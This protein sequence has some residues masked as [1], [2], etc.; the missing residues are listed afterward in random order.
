MLRYKTETRPS[1]VALYDIRLGN[2]AGQ[3]LQSRSLQGASGRR[4]G[5]ANVFHTD[6]ITMFNENQ[7]MLK[8][9]GAMTMII[10]QLIVHL[11]IISA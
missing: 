7:Q 11:A 1:L 4:G 5:Q 3:F 2:R 9:K 6:G 10:Q 8:Q